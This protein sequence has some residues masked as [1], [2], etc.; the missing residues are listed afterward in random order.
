MNRILKSI[1][2]RIAHRHLSSADRD[3]WIRSLVPGRT[4]ADIGGLWGTVN[5]KVSV[6][7]LA[8]A[9]ATTMV[10]VQPAGGKW[11][12]LFDQ[13]CA[14]LGVGGY[15][16]VCA[17]ICRPGAARELGRFDVVHCSGI[18]YHVADVFGFL[19]NLFRITGGH[20]LLTS[21][22]V[23]PRIRNLSGSLHLP[24]G[25]LLSVPAMDARARAVLARHYDLL[26]V[27]IPDLTGPAPCY[28][29]ERLRFRTGP[30]WW[31]Y[32]PETMKA[33][34]RIL[35]F[36]VMDEG[37]V[38]PG[39]TYALLLRAVRTGKQPRSMEDESR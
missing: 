31:L 20:L 28:V 2:R 26:N 39:R 29:E 33:L 12:Q 34:V 32:T 16:R 10:D 24:G 25:A 5:E 38:S 21:M 18:M 30:W 36:E 8:G 7:A 15:A 22:V 37:W 27:N 3:G 4:F 9:A 13:R 6:A 17:D 23:P 14:G 19:R 35:P 1:R 11:W